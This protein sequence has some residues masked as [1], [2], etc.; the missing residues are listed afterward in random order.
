MTDDEIQS[1]IEGC[2]IQSSVEVKNLD[3]L[4]IVA[5]IVDELGVVEIVNEYVG[6]DPHE[7]VSA[8][9]AVKAMILNGLGF[10]AAP[11]YLFE[12][13]FVG[14]PTEHLLGPGVLPQYLNDYRLGRVLDGLYLT[15]ITTVFL[16]ICME[17]VKRFNITCERAHLDATSMSVSGTYLNSTEST[18]NAATVPIQLCHGYSRDHRPDLKQFVMNLVCWQDG[19]IPAFIELADG[20]QSD[21][22]R[23]AGLIEQFQQQWDFDGVHVADAALYSSDNL[24][25]LGTLRWI[26]RVPLTLTQANEL[27]E[28]IDESAFRPSQLE[29]YRL[30]EVCCLYGGVKQRWLVVESSQ[31]QASD[32][33]QW[34]K[35]LAKATQRAQSQLDQLSRQPFA[36][37]AD[38][39]QAL[40]RFEKSLKQHLISEA[41]IVE[42]PHYD[43]PGRPAKNTT[44]TSISYH[45]QATLSLDPEADAKQ[46]RRAGRFILATNVLPSPELERDESDNAL[47]SPGLEM[48]ESEVDAIVLSAD[49]ILT[50]YKAQQ[51]PERGFRFLKDPL[52]FTSSVFLKSPERIMALGMIMGLCL[53]VYNLGQRKLRQALKAANETIPNQL[54]KLIENPTLRWIF[55]CFMAI[56]LVFINGQQQV[57]NLN[58]NHRKILRFLG[59]ASQEYYLLC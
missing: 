17:A 21:K 2:I 28:N 38:A 34:K 12:Q 26:S 30:A 3:H 18:E 4:G 33:K 16:A 31:R 24:Q 23:F 46:R 14:K 54:G 41:T 8:G 50:E 36:C 32:L 9:V 27:I 48:D 13:F 25:Q 15:G 52:F 7:K 1:L 55:Q 6:E 58:D 35:R 29:G 57:V 22:A 43:Q 59:S 10:A 19:D 56:H 5:G 20:N 40:E 39:Q 11:L 53:L 47:V 49:D 44:P 51:G 37:E 45:I 42:R